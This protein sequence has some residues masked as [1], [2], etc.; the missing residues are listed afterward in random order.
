M[1]LQQ[2]IQRK[3]NLITLAIIMGAV[4]IAV[5]IGLAAS[6]L[7]KTS[8]PKA[9]KDPITVAAEAQEKLDPNVQDGPMLKQ[10]GQ[11]EA[12]PPNVLTYRIN[13]NPQFATGG[14]QGNIMVEN[15]GVNSCL[16]AVELERDTGEVIYRSGYI[17]PNQYIQTAD[18]NIALE[19]GAYAVTASFLAYDPMT[20]ELLGILNEPI[21]ILVGEAVSVESK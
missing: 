15:P 5:V 18:L 14:K 20:L 4:A 3:N 10:T 2:E 8:G 7:N 1:R 6:Y 16:I 11:E 19:D 21:K 12:N 13:A 9:I 17:K